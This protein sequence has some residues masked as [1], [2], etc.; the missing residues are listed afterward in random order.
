MSMPRACS[1]DIIPSALVKEK[2]VSAF[3]FSTITPSPS[4]VSGGSTMGN[5]AAHR[6]ARRSDR[7]I[8]P[9]SAKASIAARCGSSA[10][11]SVSPRR[12]ETVST[13]LRPGTLQRRERGHAAHLAQA[14][15]RTGRQVEAG[16]VGAIDHVDVVIA[17]K[18]DQQSGERRVRR[19]GVEKLRPFRRNAGIGQI[20]RDQDRVE[21]MRRVD[22]VQPRQ[23][24]PQPLVAARAGPSALDPEA[25]AL[26]H[27]VDVGQMRDAP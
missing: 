20:S 23:G 13:T 4:S 3:E 9:L 24:Q 7:R 17:G 19:Q 27:G 16:R 11:A 22:L 1:Y 18:P 8:D 25:V 6:L 2:C 21:R 14:L 12:P 26:A 10:C 5:T 15:G